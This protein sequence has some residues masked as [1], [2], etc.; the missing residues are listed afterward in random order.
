MK[1]KDG[2]EHFLNRMKEVNG[3]KYT[4]IGEFKKTGLK[5]KFRCNICKKVFEK[6][7]VLN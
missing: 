7:Q 2:K 3:N 4:L 5:T 6:L 1:V